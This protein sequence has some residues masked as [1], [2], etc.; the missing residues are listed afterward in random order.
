MKNTLIASFAATIAISTASPAT[1]AI[2]LTNDLINVSTVSSTQGLRTDFGDF[3]VPEAYV[4]N[5]AYGFTLSKDSFTI[6]STSSFSFSNDIT[7]GAALY[8]VLTDLTKNMNV[9]GITLTNNGVSLP[10]NYKPSIFGGNS[11]GLSVNSVYFPVGSSLTFNLFSV[12]SAPETA[13][14]AMLVL[15]FGF[16]G[17]GMRRAQ[18]S[19]Q[20]LAVRYS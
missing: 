17:A 6:L 1:A 19:R 4:A 15:G 5:Y 8:F 2:D 9:T 12:T 14:W 18:R 16:V 10:F 20:R 13:T 11:V 7:H 3:T